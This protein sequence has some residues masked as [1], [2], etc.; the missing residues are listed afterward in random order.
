VT[1][2]SPPTFLHLAEGAAALSVVSRVAIRDTVR[3][4]LIF[5]Y[6]PLSSLI[7]PYLPLSSLIFPYLP[8]SSLISRDHFVMS[9]KAQLL[10]QATQ[11]T[12]LRV[13]LGDLIVRP[14]HRL[15]G[16]HALDRLRIHVRDY[17]FGQHFGGP[18]IGRRRISWQPAR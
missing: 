8:L 15:V 14:F 17:V 5:P 11:H 18:A 10:T 1:K 2:F 7:F 9:Q 16:P 6:L 12:P 4:S 3:S 13:S